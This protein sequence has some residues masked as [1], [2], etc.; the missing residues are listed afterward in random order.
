[1]QAPKK[2]PISQAQINEYRYL[3]QDANADSDYIPPINSIAYNTLGTNSSRINAAN[4]PACAAFAS[5]K[6][7]I[8]SNSYA[9]TYVGLS[10]SILLRAGNKVVENN[11]QLDA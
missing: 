8:T 9:S 7:G 11:K 3:L 1:V 6:Q 10:T 4:L 2:I 5:T